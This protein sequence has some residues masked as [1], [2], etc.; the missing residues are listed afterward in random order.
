MRSGANHKSEE[1]KKNGTEKRREYGI[2]FSVQILNHK[3]TRKNGMG[4]ANERE[5]E[6]TQANCVPR[7]FIIFINIIIIVDFDFNFDDVRPIGL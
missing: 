1:N 3:N 2:F 5:R 6:E 4:K 7:C